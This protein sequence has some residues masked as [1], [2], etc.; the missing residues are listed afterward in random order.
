MS[1]EAIEALNELR[2]PTLQ[3]NAMTGL[4]AAAVVAAGGEIIV[5][6][7]H[8]AAAEKAEDW[9]MDIQEREDGGI[10]ITARRKGWRT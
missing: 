8:I 6:K 10:V 2:D 9:S 3:R 7:H 1:G 5:G 4:L